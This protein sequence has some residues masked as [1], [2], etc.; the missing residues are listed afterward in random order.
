MVPPKAISSAARTAVRPA[1]ITSLTSAT[2]RPSTGEARSAEVDVGG[3]TVTVA[4]ARPLRRSGGPRGD[5]TTERVG[6]EG[7]HP[8]RSGEHVGKR[9]PARACRAAAGSHR[10]RGRPG[11][12]RGELLGDAVGKAEQER[13]P[14]AL[15][16]RRRA[17]PDAGHLARRLGVQRRV[18]HLGDVEVGL[19]AGEHRRGPVPGRSRRRPRSRGCGRRRRARA[20]RART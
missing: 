19:V 13:P 12:R 4:P 7:A 5:D 9:R 20:S 18:Q 3:G 1:S 10:R 15:R 8:R 11:P 14:P 6:G 2:Q 16:R 17:R